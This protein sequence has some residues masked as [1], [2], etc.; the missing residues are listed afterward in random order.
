MKKIVLILSVVYIFGIFISCTSLD[1]ARPDLDVPHSYVID[2]KSV[3]KNI[4]DNIR[5]VNQTSVSNISFKVYAHDSKTFIWVVYG[6]ASLKGNGDTAF[7]R[8]KLS[9]KLDKYRYF[10][11]EALDGNDYNYNYYESRDDLYIN[12]HDK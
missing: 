12:I 8:S 1:Y 11:I 5:L 3:S 4:E 9:G 7:V 10:A 6:E 2:A